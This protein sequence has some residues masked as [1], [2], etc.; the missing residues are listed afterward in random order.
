MKCKRKL[1]F[2][3]EMIYAYK[4]AEQ[5]QKTVFFVRTAKGKNWADGRQ[6]AG[7]TK[8]GRILGRLLLAALLPL[9]CGCSAKKEIGRAHV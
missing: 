3:E 8:T 1:D 2:Y 6:G 5:M 9:L 7:M 4:Q